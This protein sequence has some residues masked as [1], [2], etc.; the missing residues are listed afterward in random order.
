MTAV[1]TLHSDC[2]VFSAFVIIRNQIISGSP[3]SPVNSL[4]FAV[5]LGENRV[6]IG[7]E[8]TKTLA[9]EIAS[10]PASN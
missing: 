5:N 10:D 4:S 2:R 3:N 7:P 8:I 9:C 6:K 1:T